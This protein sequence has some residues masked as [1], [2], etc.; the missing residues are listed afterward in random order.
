M[1]H[2]NI[3]YPLLKITPANDIPGYLVLD[4]R[5]AGADLVRGPR[6]SISLRQRE[7]CSWFTQ[8]SMDLHLP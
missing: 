6:W 2:K 1:N 5:Q 8:C 4:V 7:T 3:L